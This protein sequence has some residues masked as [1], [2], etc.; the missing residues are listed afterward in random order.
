MSADIS[1]Q[2]RFL[3]AVLL[4]QKT[5]AFKFKAFPNCPTNALLMFYS[6]ENV[7]P[8]SPSLH[9]KDHF[10]AFGINIVQFPYL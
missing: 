10:F 4:G 2:N 1:V 9:S 5:H 8:P 6:C 3:K 7:L